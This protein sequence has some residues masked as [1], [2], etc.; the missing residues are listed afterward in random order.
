MVFSSMS[1][2]LL[3]LPIVLLLYYLAGSLRLKNAVL[4]CAS[5]FF[6]AWGEPVCVLAMLFSSAVNFFCAKAIASTDEP[7][8][9][10]AALAAGVGVSLALLFY[11]TLPFE[12]RVRQTL[13]ILALSP[14][15]SAVPVF[16]AELGED[17]GL[18]SAIN[19]IAIV[20]SIVLIVT[21]LL[22]MLQI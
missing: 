6:Y 21:L 7:R 19:S 8:R 11:F 1:F 22:V 20:I 4:L 12:L 16:T 9:R 15:G 17:E 5:L 2:I 10:K 18:S 3:F 14:I 13:A